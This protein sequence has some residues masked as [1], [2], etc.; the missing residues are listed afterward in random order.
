MK[1]FRILFSVVLL[2]TAGWSGI[3]LFVAGQIETQRHLLANPADPTAPTVTCGVFSVS[4]FPFQFAARCSDMVAID[5]DVTLT[6][7]QVEFIVLAYRPT[8]AIAFF[9]GPLQYSN[10]FFGTRQ[11]VRWSKLEASVRL[12]GWQMVRTSLQGE[13]IGYF[14]TLIGE[15]L[16]TR[17]KKFDLHLL[18]IPERYDADRSSGSLAAFSSAETLDAPPYTIEGGRFTFEAELSQ[19]PDDIRQ[20]T[21]PNLARLWQSAGGQLKLNRL[22]ADDEMSAIN[23]SGEISLDPAGNPNGSIIVNST[24]VVDRLGTLV[25]PEMQPLFFGKQKPDGTYQQNLTLRAG[26]LYTGIIPILQLPPLF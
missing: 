3:W 6:L 24:G 25:A 16:L 1:R 20:W 23:L 18:D 11:E 21:N 22:E 17:A 14:D 10:A 4:G 9:Q 7:G 5:G 12:N 8:H 15:Q 2:I 19:V 26:A 13:N